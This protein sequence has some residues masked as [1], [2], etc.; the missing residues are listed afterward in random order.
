M[1]AAL[2]IEPGRVEVDD[3]PDPVPG[4]GEVR[5]AV[6]GVGLCGSDSA[7]FSGRWSPPGY[8]WIMGH[9]AIGVIDAVGEGVSTARLGEP[10]A[11]EPNLVCL[12]CRQC[13]RGWTSACELRQSLGM[14]RAGALCERLV[15]PSRFAWSTAGLT[16]T[17][18][19]CVEPM[20][21]VCAALRRL[22]Q[23]S[24]EQALVVGLGAQG[25]LMALALLGRGI[26]VAVVDTDTDR[27]A[28][29]AA[30]GAEPVQSDDEPEASL[31]VNTV[32]SPQS[33]AV[34][35]NHVEVGGTLLCLGLDH[36]PMDLNAERLVR[37]QVVLRGSLTYDHPGDFVETI[38]QIRDGQLAP[39]IAVTDEY[40]LERTQAAF[41]ERGTRVGKSWIRVW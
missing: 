21:V 28:F 39:G 32:G 20:T 3:V 34:A 35:L 10:V 9:E 14:N 1:K 13:R 7:V 38:A 19:L 30:H 25:M 16:I 2:L 23:P 27:V 12:S 18:R 6:Y 11:V 22:G 24:V 37:R 8:P 36:R 31:V 33:M 4:L 40:P 15:V 17:D 41:E 5:V 29:A 26:S